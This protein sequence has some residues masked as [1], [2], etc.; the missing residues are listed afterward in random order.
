M[1]TSFFNRSASRETLKSAKALARI[2]RFD[3]CGWGFELRVWTPEEWA[4][5]TKRPP[6][7]E[8]IELAGGRGF[9]QIVC[10]DDEGGPQPS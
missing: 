3:L 7:D 9:A 2:G 10:L 5:E 8:L 4:A 1:L 6:A